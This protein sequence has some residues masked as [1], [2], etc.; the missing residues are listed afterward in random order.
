M[1]GQVGLGFANEVRS[2]PVGIVAAAG[3]GRPGGGDPARRGRRRRVADRRGGRAR[4]SAEVGGIMFREG[5]AVLAADDSDETRCSC[6]S[7]R[8]ARSS[9]ARQGGHRRA[10]GHRGVGRLEGRRGAVRGPRDA[11]GG[12]VRGGRRRRPT[13]RG[14]WAAGRPPHRRPPARPV[15]GRVAR[16]EAVTILAP[17]WPDRRQRGHGDAATGSSTSAGG[18]H[19][20]PPHP[21]VDL[22]VRLG[23]LGDAADATASAAC[24]WTSSRPRVPRRSR[25]RARGPLGALA[26]RPAG[27]RPRV[28]HRG[29]PAGRAAPDG[30]AAR[31][32]RGRRPHQRRGGAAG[33]GALA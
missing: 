30:R 21:M 24:C 28:R 22:E 5:M 2:G 6:P 18:V 7:R 13:R 12:G 25:R 15:L 26:G 11:R 3:T 4:P 9:G 27:D 33:G 29:R 14:S 10:A 31:L 23:M 1:L 17:R 20:G 32:R 8:A 19:P 16:H